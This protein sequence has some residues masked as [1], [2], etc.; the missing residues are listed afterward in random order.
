MLCK[1]SI[2]AFWRMWSILFRILSKATTS[3]CV[4][5]S[6]RTSILITMYSNYVKMFLIIYR[7]QERHYKKH[8]FQKSCAETVIKVKKK[9]INKQAKK[10]WSLTKSPLFIHWHISNRKLV[11]EQHFLLKES[12]SKSTTVPYPPWGQQCGTSSLQGQ[13]TYPRFVLQVGAWAHAPP[14]QREGSAKKRAMLADY[15]EQLQ[16]VTRKFTGFIK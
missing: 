14:P 10:L 8:I 11:E 9:R 15:A 3:P 5:Q 1:L 16:L 2:C 6:R 7:K 12:T 13:H 4:G